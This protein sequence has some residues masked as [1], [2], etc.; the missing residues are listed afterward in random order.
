M[1]L[2]YDT[3][4]KAR[5]DTFLTEKLGLS[6]NKIQ[7]MIISG[8]IIVNGKGVSKHYG[9]L[10]GDR[11]EVSTNELKDAKKVKKFKPNKKVSFTVLH[12]DPNYLII[13]K[14]AGLLVHPTE[15]M[16]DDTLANGLIAHYKE[17][18]DVGDHELRP[19]IVHRLDKNV[20]GLLLVARN[21]K[22]FEYYKDLFKSRDITKIYHA[23]VHGIMEMPTGDITLR[24]SRSKTKG[25]MAA[26]P[27]G[28][29]LGKE[30]HTEY[31][32]LKTLKHFSY[33][34]VQIHTGRTHQIR[35]HLNALEHPIVGDPLYKQRAVKQK[36]HV[37]RPFLHAKELSFVDQEGNSVHYESKLPKE[38]DDILKRI[39]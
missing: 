2:T 15:Q 5:I 39:D 25:R 29:D 16:E 33:L 30:A 23:L 31:E 3:T 11:I 38:F 37:Q 13:D 9:L 34:K 21:Q 8:D 27:A 18:K 19:G 36:L 24:I 4:E 10:E 17:L 35:A 32:V 26:H 1:K 22:A 20:S 12:E 28:S 14:Q 7:K 6:R